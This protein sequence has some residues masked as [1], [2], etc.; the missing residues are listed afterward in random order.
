[1]DPLPPEPALIAISIAAK[2][3]SSRSLVGPQA[4]EICRFLR[5]MVVQ[6]FGKWKLG[7]FD[8]Q[9]LSPVESISLNSSVLVGASPL[10]A[11]ENS[12][13]CGSVMLSA[14]WITPY[15]PCP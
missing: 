8:H 12:Q 11:N 3:L 6:S 2:F 14:R 4:N 15:P 7:L 10:I 13:F 5:V 9:T 1:M